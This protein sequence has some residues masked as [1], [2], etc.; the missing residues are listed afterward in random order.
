M[1]QTIQEVLE[2]CRMHRKVLKT[3][4]VGPLKDVYEGLS[5]SISK[6]EAVL[7]EGSVKVGTHQVPVDKLYEMIVDEI[8]KAQFHKI[9]MKIQKKFDKV[10]RK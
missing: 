6:L 9:I 5:I 3:N 1:K 7:K 8:P 2:A 4:A 10:G